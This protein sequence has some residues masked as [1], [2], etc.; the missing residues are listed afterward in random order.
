MKEKR[1]ENKYKGQYIYKP[2]AKKLC[3]WE[4]AGVGREENK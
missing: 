4:G 1:S 3:L 2:P